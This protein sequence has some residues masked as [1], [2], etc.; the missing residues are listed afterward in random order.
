VAP[1]QSVRQAQHS[2]TERAARNPLLTT[3]TTRSTRSRA[4]TARPDVP[5]GLDQAREQTGDF[6]GVTER[7]DE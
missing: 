5:C 1:R 6:H 7:G 2:L 3:R 4:P